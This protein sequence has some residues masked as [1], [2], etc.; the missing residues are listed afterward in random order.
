MKENKDIQNVENKVIIVREQQVIVDRDVAE[1]YGVETKK[2]NQAV[3]RNIDKFP[4]GYRFFLNAEEKKELVTNCD[5]FEPL[6]HSTV[7]PQ[8]FTEKGLY[9]L[10]TILKSPMATE[11]TISI[12]ETFAKLRVL[13]RTIQI[14]NEAAKNGNPPTEKESSKVQKMM[15]EVFTNNLPVK[16][17]K[18]TFGINFGVFKFSVE[19]TREKNK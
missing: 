5:R 7:M 13:S 14:A 12:I 3:S 17:Q 10:A 16:M 9:M 18:T 8:A 11:V 1:L 6:K 19:T 15:N 4:D 2:I